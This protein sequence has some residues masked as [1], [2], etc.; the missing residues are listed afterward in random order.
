MKKG[1][2]LR[3]G[4]QGEILKNVPFATSEPSDRLLVLKLNKTLGEKF[5]WRRKNPA[6]HWSSHRRQNHRHRRRTY[7]HRPQLWAN[8]ARPCGERRWLNTRLQTAASARCCC[9]SA[10]RLIRAAQYAAVIDAE[11]PMVDVRRGLSREHPLVKHELQSRTFVVRGLAR[12]RSEL[13]PTRRVGRP[14]Y[15][16]IGITW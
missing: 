13:E 1:P 16:G 11:G 5:S 6:F 10:V 12:L 9:R 7:R 2:R 15:G 4:R 14:G 8:L 3:T